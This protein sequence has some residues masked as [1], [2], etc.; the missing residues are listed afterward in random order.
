[1]NAWLDELATQAK[2]PT[3]VETKFDAFLMTE[4]KAQHGGKTDE[5]IHLIHDVFGFDVDGKDPLPPNE[6]AEGMSR[7]K[8]Y[9]DGFT[10]VV[11]AA[12]GIGSGQR[13]P[14]PPT[15]RRRL[16]VYWGCGQPMNSVVVDVNAADIVVV[17]VFSTAVPPGF[18]KTKLRTVLPASA[19]VVDDHLGLEQIDTW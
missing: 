1:M 12:F 11:E 5:H 4:D 7:R 19:T 15:D 13:I 8:V 17:H 16:D 9:A 2:A 6:K 18:D 3:D 14:D 10:R